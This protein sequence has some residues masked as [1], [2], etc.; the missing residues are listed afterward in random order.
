[1]ARHRSTTTGQ[2]AGRMAGMSTPSTPALVARSIAAARS[3]S[4]ASRSRWQWVSITAGE[5]LV[6]T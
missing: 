1:M 2:V 6:M 5:V 3:A 4:N